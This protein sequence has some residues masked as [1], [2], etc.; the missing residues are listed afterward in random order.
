MRDKENLA[1]LVYDSMTTTM[2]MMDLQVVGTYGPDALYE[3]ATSPDKALASFSARI[4][5]NVAL[6]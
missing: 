1:V 4:P 2:R 5:T 6:F 3:H